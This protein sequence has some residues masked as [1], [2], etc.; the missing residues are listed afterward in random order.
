MYN[1]G[2]VRTCKQREFKNWSIMYLEGC[3]NGCW[4]NALTIFCMASV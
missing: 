3:L 4:M 1:L 2:Q